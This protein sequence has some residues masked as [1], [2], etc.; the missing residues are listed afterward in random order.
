MIPLYSTPRCPLKSFIREPYSWHFSWCGWPHWECGMHATIIKFPKYLCTTTS[1]CQ[2]SRTAH[3]RTWS[4]SIHT[5]ATSTNR[6]LETKLQ[7]F[8]HLSVGGILSCPPHNPYYPFPNPQGP[9]SDPI[10]Q[11]NVNFLQTTPT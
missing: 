6:P 4:I 7:A 3:I 8:F 11:N 1:T 10:P 2:S 5:S 9:P